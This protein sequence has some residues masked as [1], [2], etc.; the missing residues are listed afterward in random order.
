MRYHQNP[1]VSVTAV[2]GD[3]F[4]VLPGG[5]DV[6]YLDA[7]SSGLWRM[8]AEPCTLAALQTAYRSAFPERDVVEVDGDV[9]AAFGALHARGL[10]VSAP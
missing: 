7:V 9:A 3:T 10:V 4:L 5:D 8:L 1:D 6:F 2:E